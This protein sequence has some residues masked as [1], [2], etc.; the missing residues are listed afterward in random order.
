MKNFSCVRFMENDCGSNVHAG[1]EKSVCF[2]ECPLWRGFV[3]R[4]SL[5]NRPG[6]NFF[7]RLR[8]VSA[9]ECVRFREVPLYLFFENL[10]LF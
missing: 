7:V 9:L 2:M 6:Q 8:E 4:D 3:K 5:G 10:C 1:F